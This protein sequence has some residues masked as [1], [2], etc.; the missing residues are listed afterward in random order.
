MKLAALERVTARDRD[1]EDAKQLAI[2]LGITTVKDLTLAYN[3][4]FPNR[5][6][7]RQA[8]RRLPEL[9]NSINRER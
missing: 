8:I 2:E 1:F 6:L 3:A 9:E 4:Y 5:P 7:P